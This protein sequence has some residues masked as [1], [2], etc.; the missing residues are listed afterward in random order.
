MAVLKSSIVIDR[1]MVKRNSQLARFS[2]VPSRL[3]GGTRGRPSINTASSGRWNSD[4]D[5]ARK[6]VATQI[7]ESVKT[8]WGTAV[9]VERA[10]GIS[11]TEFSRI[12]NGKL[13]RFS[14]D[15]LVWLLWIIDQDVE[16]TLQVEAKRNKPVQSKDRSRK[17]HL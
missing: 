5:V 4:V 8:K 2:G 3:A 9:A 10:T 15:R 14:L 11:Q 16:V 17:H 12:R 1:I 7:I 13:A 6:I